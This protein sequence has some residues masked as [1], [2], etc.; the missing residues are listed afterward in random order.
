MKVP[1]N[2]MPQFS[3]V[4]LL[5]QR[6]RP[7]QGQLQAAQVQA[8]IGQ[9]SMGIY[10]QLATTHIATRDEH[11]SADQEKLRQLAKDSQVAARCFFEGIGV[12]EPA[13]REQGD[14]Q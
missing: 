3:Q 4:P 5:N 9:I 7:T 11:Q 14:S 10:S 6:Q 2:N 12:I 8:A 1:P 13:P